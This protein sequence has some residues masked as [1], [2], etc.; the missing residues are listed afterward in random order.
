M[1]DLMTDKQKG[2]FFAITGPL[3]WGVTGILAETLLYNPT[4]QTTWVTSMRLV[5]GG[6]VLMA[7]NLM[8]RKSLFGVFKNMRDLLKLIFFAIFC[9][10]A[11]QFTYYQTIIY[12]DARIATIL[13]FTN[14]AFVMTA[15]A[16]ENKMLPRRQDVIA[17]ISALLGVFLLVTHGRLDSLFITP[18]ALTWGIISIVACVLYA[19]VPRSLVGKYESSTIMG[20][21]MLIGGAAFQFV[22]PIWHDVPTLSTGDIIR[23][24]L[25]IIFGTAIAFLFILTSLKYITADTMTLLSSFEPITVFLI[26]VTLLKQPFTGYDVVGTILILLTVVIQT[27]KP[28]VK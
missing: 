6:I 25:I 17:L 3:L 23:L 7:Y 15:V 10:A 9:L 13:Q 4:V 26:S 21:A 18:Q 11:V 19:L 20:W 22:R 24:T 12:S 5:F 8:T 1:G 28:T 14:A 2:L 16:L 27:M